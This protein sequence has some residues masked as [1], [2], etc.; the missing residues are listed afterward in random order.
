MKKIAIIGHRRTIKPIVGAINQYFMDIEVVEIEFTDIDM[1]E[2]TVEYI[3]VSIPDLN[4]IIFTGYRPF[5]IIN[6]AMGINIPQIYI[7]HERSILLQTILEAAMIN[8]YDI[9]SFSCDSYD[10]DNLYDAFEGFNIPKEE[11]LLFTAPINIKSGRLI[12]E[13]TE[14]HREKYESGEV[15]FC[16]TG[17]SKVYERLDE[18]GIPCLLMHPTSEAVNNGINQLYMKI[19]ALECSESQIVVLSIEIDLPKEYNLIHD[20]EYQLMLEKS[21]V[22]EEIYKFSEQI[23]AAVVEPGS[24]NFMLFSTRQLLES[25]TS[26][27][28]AIPV[29]GEVNRNTSHTISIGIGYGKTA[30]EA[31]YNAALGLN[32]ALTQGGNQAFY[33][34]EGKYSEPILPSNDDQKPKT[35]TN[36]FYKVVSEKTGISINNIYKLHCIQEKFKKDFFTSAELSE[37]FGNTRRSMNRIISKLEAVGYVEIEGTRMMSD[38]GRPTRIIRLKL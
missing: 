20:N 19:N 28:N 13:L 16:M 15:S 35:I 17:V 8:D 1:T 2:A 22:S 27:L 4:G 32:R 12:M 14:F 33:V 30:R 7:Q 36:P 6:E 11:L 25:V 5:E 26:Q 9:R 34:K 24:K 18:S 3:K 37:A 29:L 23:Q 21:K 38:T 31:K 10:I